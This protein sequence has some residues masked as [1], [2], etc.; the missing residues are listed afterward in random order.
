VYDREEDAKVS[1][2]TRIDGVSFA[3]SM[4][5]NESADNPSPR[6][7]G[8]AIAFYCEGCGDNIELT[9]SQHK[10]ETLVDWRFTPHATNSP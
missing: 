3:G 7:H 10:G 1:Q 8:I 6:R 4:L 9:L 5:T 2:V